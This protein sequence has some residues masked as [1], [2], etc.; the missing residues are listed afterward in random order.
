MSIGC[1]V[2]YSTLLALFIATV[3]V[4]PTHSDWTDDIKALIDVHEGEVGVAIK[5][6]NSGKSF[7]HRGDAVQATASLIK[8]PVLIELYKQHEAGKVSLDKMITLRDE[9]KVPGSGILTDHFPVGTQIPLRGVAQLMM[10]F[11]DNT[12]TNLVIDQVGLLAVVATMDELGLKE[13]R[14]NSKVYKRDT[15][16]APDRSE[17]Y[18]LGSTT[19][20][21]MVKLLELLHAKKL[22]S[23]TASEQ[24]LKHMAACDDASKIRRFLPK[25][26][27]YY[28]KTGA[29][30]NTRTD[31]GI[32]EMPGG[33]VAIAILTT[34]NRDASWGN[35]NAAEILCGKI[36]QI[37]FNEFSAV[38]TPKASDV[39]KL[40]VGASGEMVEALQRALNKKVKMDVALTVDGDFGSMT[41]SALRKF[42]SENGLPPTGV[43]DEA[44]WQKLGP[45]EFQDDATSAPEVVNAEKLT[46]LPPDP[47]DGLPFVS[48]KAWVVAHAKS[49][50]VLASE[51]LDDRL[52]IASTTKIMT[53]WLVCKECEKS[54][55]TLDET[56]IFSKRADDTIGSSATVRAGESLSIRE[57]LYGLMLP[58]G[59]DMSVALAEHFGARFVEPSGADTQDP[60]NLFVAAMNREA[61]RLGMLNTMYQ[62][63]HGLTAK[64]HYSSCADL[65]L[66]A[67]TALSSELIRNVVSTRQHG[68]TV[69]SQSG[70]SRN[71]VWKNTNVLLGT[72][73][74]FGMKTGTTDAAGACL[75]SCSQ[76]G[77][78]SLI[79][80]VLGAS[81][82]AAR[83]S[84]SRNLHRW[85]RQQL[86]KK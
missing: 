52:D 41:A 65:V 60:L 9:D 54:P 75:V 13:T 47:V 80:V 56:L 68:C 15:S 70:Y 25:T 63:P 44:T 36:G 48:C 66:L 28:H 42:Q 32:F 31:A 64:N 3:F 67:R 16:V 74:Y 14:L 24:M 12:A 51:K 85:G 39:A 58:S 11:S 59:N 35:E 55:A 26:V 38:D 72:E 79:V 71:I 2:R 61:Q 76:L 29:V 8:F 19:A 45:L 43:V 57:A 77:E 27:K 37:V 40:A 1:L 78:D 82:S 83:Y 34:K 6:L 10:A 49:G 62:N 73:G 5:H 20:N 18:G 46:L 86:Q 30:A 17:K 4:R 33:P 21:D 23:Q 53:A 69:Q 50:K 81:G 22:V 84:D 7:V